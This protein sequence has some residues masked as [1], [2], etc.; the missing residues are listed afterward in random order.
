MRRLVVILTWDY[1]DIEENS[2]IQ[3]ITMTTFVRSFQE[4]NND[5]NNTRTAM[6]ITFFAI[7]M[8]PCHET[9]TLSIRITPFF[10]MPRL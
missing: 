3:F 2:K 1:L 6:K 5:K 9:Q 10:V 8:I 7:F 4:F